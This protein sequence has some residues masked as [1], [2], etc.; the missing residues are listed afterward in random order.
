MDLTKLSRRYEKA[1]CSHLLLEIS[2]HGNPERLLRLT[3][4]DR[5][6]YADMQAQ[7]SMLKQRALCEDVFRS[8]TF[9]SCRQG[10]ASD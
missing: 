10:N 4:A 1:A 7:L 5:L 8:Q 2:R 6:G 9:F 3:H